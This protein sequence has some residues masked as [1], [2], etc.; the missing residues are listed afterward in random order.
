[1]DIAALSNREGNVIGLMPHPERVYYN[2]QMM[3]DGNNYEKG[4]GQIFFDALYE[5]TKKLVS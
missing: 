2:F 3:N 5:Y 1:M 4:T